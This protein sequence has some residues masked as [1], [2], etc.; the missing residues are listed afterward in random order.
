MKS[1]PRD[2]TALAASAWNSTR[3]PADPEF[4]FCATPHQGKLESA[5]I[6]IEE[7]GNAGIQGLEAF[8][9]EVKRLLA[10]PTAL[11]IVPKKAKS[12]PKPKAVKAAKKGK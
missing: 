2:V 7:S 3:D 6:A 11:A 9:A 10:P 4:A 8:E 5:V 12:A 1:N